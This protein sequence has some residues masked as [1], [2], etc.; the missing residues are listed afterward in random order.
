MAELPQGYREVPQED[1]DKAEVFFGHGRAVA[2]TGNYDYAISMFIDGLNLDPDSVPAHQELRDISLKRRVSGG[3]TMGWMESMKLKKPGGDDKAHMLAGE[4]LLG[5]DPGNTDY[6]LTVFQYAFRAGYYDTV[7]WMGPILQKANQED[8]KSDFKKYIV[9]RDVY[10]SLHQWRLAT[11]ACQFALAMSPQDMELATEVKNLGAMETIDT[12]GYSKAGSFREQ[13]KDMNRQ[14]RLLIGDKDINDMSQMQVLIAQAEMEHKAEPED[15]GK[16]MKLVDVLDKT[17]HPDFESR[18]IELLERFHKSLGH[19]RFRRRIG[20][21]NMKQLGR[22]EKSKR[23]A[24]AH[25]PQNAELAKDWQEFHRE[26]IEYE[27]KEF[28]LAADAYPTELKLRYEIGKRLFQ[29]GATRTPFRSS[30]RRGRI[31]NIGWIR[32]LRWR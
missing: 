28:Q 24:L 2:G 15:V 1:R 21:I 9:L 31:R 3:K 8:K 23:M 7:M 22:M 27:M 5:Y 19:F 18:A 20:E 16:A 13:V 32:R 6:M 29:M 17:D 12:A 26:Q 14:S 30:S 11:D 10:K 4:K 25:D